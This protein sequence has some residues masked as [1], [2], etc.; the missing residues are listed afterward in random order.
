MKQLKLVVLLVLLGVVQLGIS[1]EQGK[2]RVGLDFGYAFP[3]GGGGL[4]FAIEPKYNLNEKMNVGF[5]W[6][7]ALM[8]REV[9][10]EN[11]S[12][13]TGGE[14]KG[15][16]IYLAT[17]DYYFGE[18]SSFQPFAGAGIGYSSIAGIS[19]EG[20]TIGD[21]RAEVASEGEFGGMVRA[22]FETRKFRVGIN[23]YLIRKSE[24]DIRV[25]SVTNKTT[26]KNSYLGINLGFYFGGGKWNK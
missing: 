19:F 16:S 6:E 23:Y 21:S 24:G 25:G 15:S 12:T 14:I 4:S 11:G 8:A 2:V 26:S 17:Y 7:M 10:V 9:E 1:Q 3:K 20:T 18:E 5:R 13:L 22:G